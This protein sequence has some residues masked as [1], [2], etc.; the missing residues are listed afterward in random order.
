MSGFVSRRIVA[1]FRHQPLT[2][3]KLDTLRMLAACPNGSCAVYGVMDGGVLAA[4]V[5][6][7]LAERIPSDALGGLKYRA[8]DAAGAVLAE[9]AEAQR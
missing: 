7:G 2:Q 3:V 5:M 1:V 9:L 6:Y 4:L 8:T